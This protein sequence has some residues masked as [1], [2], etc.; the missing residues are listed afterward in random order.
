MVYEN[1]SSLD[2]S[3]YRNWLQITK[4]RITLTRITTITGVSTL[5]FLFCCIKSHVVNDVAIVA[6]GG[7]SLIAKEWFAVLISANKK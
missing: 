1:D 3:N 5:P 6:L 7:F 2:N 4:A